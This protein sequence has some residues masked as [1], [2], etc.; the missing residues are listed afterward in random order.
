M[1]LVRNTAWR[2]VAG[3]ALLILL[4]GFL[5][6]HH[7][8]EPTVTHVEMYVPGIRLPHGISY[9]EERLSLI[10]VLTST[11]NSD[12]HPPAF[13]MMMWFWTKCFG[14]S[15]WA[16]RLPSALLG[17]ACIPLVFWLGMLT[18]QPGAGWIAAA[19]VAV[20]GHLVF[21]SRIARM[22]TLACFLG[23]LATILL[24]KI[25]QHGRASTTLKFLYAA[26]MLLGLC[27]HIFFWLILAAHMF[28][29]LASAWSHNQPLPGA[30][31]LQFLILILGS[32]LLASSAYQNGNTLAALSSNVLVYAREYLQFGFVFP[33]MGYSSGVYPARG[34]ILLTDDPHLSAWRWLFFLL[35]AALFVI[36]ALSMRESEDKFLADTSG[37]S[38]KAWLSAAALAALAIL[39]FVFVARTYA[40]PPNPTLRTAQRMI[41]LPFL[42]ALAAIIIQKFWSSLIT[43]RSGNAL[44]HSGA[45]ASNCHPDRGLQP[46]RRDLRFPSPNARRFLA[47]EQALILIL[48]VVPFVTLAFVSL[49]KSIF[50]ARG[51]ILITP[52]L[53]LVLAAGIVR[54]ARYPILAAVVL[55]AVGS[56]NYL[57]LRAYGHA[58]AG[59]ADYKLIAAELSPQIGSTDLIFLNPEFFSTPLFYY[60]ADWNHIVGRNYEAACRGNPQARVWALQFYNYE[61]HLRDS[62]VQALSNY[63]VLRTVDAPGGQ[64]SLYVRTNF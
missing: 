55:L 14:T 52:Y 19:L 57:G 30:V 10:K 36:G 12:T 38:W 23:L 1:T 50:N 13:Y 6:L 53:L 43:W 46:E 4:G 24:L 62:I 48:A 27:T 22:F 51:L 32:P 9:P 29:T 34:P 16:M 39:C 21:W 8:G 64:A 28:W 20:N 59:R 42:L 17:M 54:L 41:I 63:H 11:L 45:E 7:L 56:A 15:T 5:R 25:A 61:P 49:F 60:M 35:S 31:K 37:P 40:A 26:I 18:R 44:K 58:S 2:T 33:L 3:L 47:G